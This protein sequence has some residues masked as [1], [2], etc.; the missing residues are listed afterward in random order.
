MNFECCSA[1]ILNYDCDVKKCHGHGVR[2]P[3]VVCPS[4][5]RHTLTCPSVRQACNS[6]KNCH[7]ADG[8]APPFC[9]LK[10]YGGSVDSGPTWNGTFTILF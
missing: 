5:C 7:C 10:G 3:P 6:N 1:K 8:W 4:V 2:R 9:E